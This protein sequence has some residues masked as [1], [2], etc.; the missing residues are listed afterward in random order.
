MTAAA[1]KRLKQRPFCMR[2]SCRPF[3]SLFW[4][5]P[6]SGRLCPR[7]LLHSLCHAPPR[8]PVGGCRGFRG[9]R[10]P[11]SAALLCHPARLPGR[12]LRLPRFPGDSRNLRALL[13]RDPHLDDFSSIVWVRAGAFI[14]AVHRGSESS[15][16][17]RLWQAWLQLEVWRVDLPAPLWYLY[18]FGLTF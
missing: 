5:Q 18:I 3:S 15:T 8:R 2:L 12:G 16:T 17:L 7:V 4:T 11:Q 6:F 1:P 14:D 13:Q 10:H 9:R